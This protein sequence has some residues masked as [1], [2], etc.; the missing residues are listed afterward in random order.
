MGNKTKGD[1]GLQAGKRSSTPKKEM[2]AIEVQRIAIKREELKI[3]RHNMSILKKAGLISKNIDV[4]NAKPTKHYKGLIRQFADVISGELKAVF[5]SPSECVSKEGCKTVKR[6]GKVYTLINVPKGVVVRQTKQGFKLVDLFDSWSG[7]KGNDG[8]LNLYRNWERQIA[9][10][11]PVG[12]LPREMQDDLK[13][14]KETIR[15]YWTLGKDEKAI[16]PN[17]YRLRLPYKSDITE[18]YSELVRSVGF[19]SNSSA[20]GS[21]VQV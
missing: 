9:G 11:T 1:K 4:R 12:E 14:L 20:Y 5:G 21:Q 7:K 6:G 18:R 16:A 8:G 3:Y 19:N 13:F 15:K 10:N 2:T 17:E